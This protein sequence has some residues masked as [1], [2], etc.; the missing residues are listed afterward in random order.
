MTSVTL[1]IRAALAYV[2]RSHR[3]PV[4]LLIATCCIL[5]SWLLLIP[6]MLWTLADLSTIWLLITSGVATLILLPPLFFLGYCV[7]TARAIRN[8][9]A[10][11]PSWRGGWR[12]LM[13]GLLFGVVLTIWTLPVTQMSLLTPSED[14]PPLPGYSFPSFNGL[15]L[16]GLVWVVFLLFAYPA[17]W[18]QYIT[19]GFRAAFNLV[20]LGRRVRAH[21]RLTLVTALLGL[22]VTLL[23]AAGLAVFGFGLLLTLPYACF[24]QAHL[25]G[26]Y[27]RLTDS[28]ASQHATSNR[29]GGWFRRVAPKFAVRALVV[30]VVA[31]PILS[32]VA[33]VIRPASAAAFIDFED[34]TTTGQGQGGQTHVTN[35]YA[36]RGVTFNDAY[37][38]DYSKGDAL[39]G[40]A[41]SGTKA[42]EQCYGVEFCSSP[43]EMLLAQPTS[44]IKVWV[45]Y[46]YALN[47][48]STVVLTAFGANGTQ[49]GVATTT[50]PASA[51][52]RPIQT[53]LQV[54]VGSASIVRA[55]V[56]FSD[57]SFT[58]GLAV[59]DVEVDQPGVPVCTATANPS[60]GA[61]PLTVQFQGSANNGT[62]GYTYSWAFGDGG[63]AT[64]KTASHTYTHSGAYTAILTVVDATIK[65][66]SKSLY[67]QVSAVGD[68]TA[69]IVHIT[70]PTNGQALTTDS[71]GRFHLVG[72]IIE[73]GTLASLQVE[74]TSPNRPTPSGPSA[75]AF[76]GPKS[77]GPPDYTFDAPTVCC[78]ADG[79]N[80][81]TVRATDSAGNVGQASVMVTR[82]LVPLDITI[83]A[84]EVTQAVQY[85]HP[86]DQTC[87][88]THDPCTFTL[89]NN[90][91]PLMRGK[92]IALRVY[93]KV[94]GA[95]GPIT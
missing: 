15:R 62:P 47:T 86:L 66:C 8:G 60:S 40:F 59:D 41:H 53:P 84:I 26:Q 46:S 80:T 28:S 67:V 90:T 10:E 64:G 76:T 58:S 9:A 23:G 68:T 11:L 85:A 65:S 42:I 87:L 51:S 33:P 93:P 32:T 70:T 55:Q 29:S 7:A 57:G 74:G 38:L 14:L 39:P 61:A 34:L 25:F 69:P 92:D 95:T 24:V 31:L 35:Q 6:A 13:D 1:D 43:I 75:L 36:S 4:K 77:P 88:N 22:L 81:I 48:T 21:L 83:A 2:F 16:L 79:Q 27:A 49:L 30:L 82:E 52:P 19:G 71:L 94:T 3:W 89:Q 78:L 17:I 12:K 45:G 54:T 20:Q 63:S 5:S 72:E 91:L 37:A 18:S 44:R 50:F 56:K 73:A